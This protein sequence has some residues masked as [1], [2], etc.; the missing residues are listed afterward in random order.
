M[1]DLMK[2]LPS[3]INMKISATASSEMKSE[4]TPDSLFDFNAEGNFGGDLTYKVNFNTIKKGDDYYFK[5]NNFPNL[6]FFFLGDISFIKGKWV[7]ISP[8]NA[9]STNQYGYSFLASLGE[10]LPAMEKTFKEKHDRIVNFAKTAVKIADEEKLITFK[11]KP[12]VE[13]VDGKQLI[14][15]ELSLRKE[16]ILP[17]YTRLQEEIKKDPN[18]SE[19]SFMIDQGLIDYLQSNEFQQVFDY[20]N[21]NNTFVL[22]TDINGFPAIIQNSMRVVP[23]DTAKQLKDKQISITF[24]VLINKINEPPNIQAPS[25]STSIEDLIKEQT[26]SR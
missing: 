3:D 25:D 10:Q 14:R 5:I 23:P 20:V 7:R 19:L 16:A 4:G 18:L 2:T 15:Y 13:K 22:W 24:K 12:R 6:F 8:S 21:K 26:P 17:F 9:S 1:A 11:A